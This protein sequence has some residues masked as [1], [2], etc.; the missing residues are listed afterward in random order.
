MTI[1]GEQTFVDILTLCRHGLLH[2]GRADFHTPTSGFQMLE[3]ITTFTANT[4]SAVTMLRF[5]VFFCTFFQVMLP[6][7]AKISD[8]MTTQNPPKRQENE[9]FFLHDRSCHM[10]TIKP[11]SIMLA[12]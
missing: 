9:P 11:F 6:G 12:T 2:L 5:S 1:L 3:I 10:Y 8:E 4:I 7:Q